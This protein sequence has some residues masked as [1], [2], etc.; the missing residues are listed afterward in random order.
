MSDS[1]ETSISSTE[2]G[3]SLLL[4]GLTPSLLNSSAWKEEIVESSECKENDKES[5]QKQKPQPSKPEKRL[6]SNHGINLEQEQKNDSYR[7][8]DRA[9]HSTAIGMEAPPVRIVDLVSLLSHRF[10]VLHLLFLSLGYQSL[11]L[12]LFIHL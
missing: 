5:S 10:L 2:E 1:D 3:F 6:W 8:Y 11:I 12:L 7:C 4:G 9:F